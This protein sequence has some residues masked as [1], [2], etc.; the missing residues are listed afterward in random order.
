MC[1]VTREDEIRNKFI[2]SNAIPVVDKINVEG[3]RG[4]GKPKKRWIDKIENDK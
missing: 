4:I 1:E 3:K 2:R